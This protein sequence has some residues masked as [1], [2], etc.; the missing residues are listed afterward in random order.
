MW[1]FAL[2]FV[3]RSGVDRVCHQLLIHFGIINTIIAICVHI[4]RFRHLILKFVRIDFDF[5]IAF[6]RIKV[7]Y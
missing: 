7:Y 4:I 5:D 2:Y 3:F 1:I 6:N